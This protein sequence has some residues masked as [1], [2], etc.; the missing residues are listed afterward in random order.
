MTHTGANL[1]VDEKTVNREGMAE[2]LAYL[3]IK[4]CEIV[5]VYACVCVCDSVCVCVR[6]R[7]RERERERECV[8]V[9]STANREGIAQALASLAIKVCEFV[10]VY[11]CACVY[12]CVCVFVCVCVCV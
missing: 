6:E 12:A 9:C 5:C 1:P 10:C 2:A 11:A 8:C 3:A 7:D 4:V